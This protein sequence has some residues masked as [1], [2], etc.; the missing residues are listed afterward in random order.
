MDHRSRV[1]LMSPSALVLYHDLSLA[2]HT[3]AVR[4]SNQLITHREMRIVDSVYDTTEIE[5]K[6]SWKELLFTVCFSTLI[7]ILLGIR[8]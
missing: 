2:K 8:A 4:I 7:F 6:G 1:L 3:S 5:D